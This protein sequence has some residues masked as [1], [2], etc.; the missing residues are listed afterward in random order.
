MHE[1]T[2]NKVQYNLKNVHI[3]IINSI[4]EN[5]VPTYGDVFANPG[6]VSIALSPQGNTST[7]YADGIAYFTTTANN[8]YSGDLEAARF[9]DQFR[10][11]ILKEELDSTDKV[12][13]ENAMAKDKAFALMFEFDGDVKAVR[14]IFYNCKATR[15]NVESGT[16]T[17][18]VEV[19]TEKV[20][21]TATPL[22]NGWVKAKTGKDTPDEKYNKWYET[23]WMPAASLPAAANA[24]SENTAEQPKTKEQEV[25]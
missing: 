8:G 21:I 10:A 22:P 5:G 19:K 24:Q 18:S 3:A 1:A 7:F 2:E 11:E 15:P 4:A 14:H 12:L 23:P 9:V 20:T 13:L 16:N 17:D 25:K 6:A